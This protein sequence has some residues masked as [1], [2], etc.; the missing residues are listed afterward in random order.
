ME[1]ISII[2]GTT[3]IPWKSI[4]LVLSVMAAFFLS[5][6]LYTA[7]KG[8]RIGMWLWAPP[9]VFLSLFFCRALYWYCNR[10]QYNDFSAAIRDYTPDGFAMLGIVPA[11]VLA[12]VFIRLI[13]LAKSLP[14]MLDAIAPGIS[15]GMGLS[16]LMCLF[17]IRCRGKVVVS[18]PV[19][20]HLPFSAPMTMPQGGVEYRFATFFIGFLV[21]LGIMK[22]CMEFYAA[23]SEEKGCTAALFL[24]L[25]SA[26]GFILDSTRYDAGYFPFNGFVSV[27][28][29]FAGLS[30][31]GLAIG[32]CVRLLKRRG[33]VWYVIPWWVAMLLSM[34]ATGYLEYLVQRYGDRYLLLYSL[35]ALSCL[36]MVLLVYV[37]YALGRKKAETV[38]ETEEQPQEPEPEKTAAAEENT[39]AVTA[40]ENDAEEEEENPAVVPAGLA[41]V[42][43]VLAA[44]GFS[45]LL[46]SKKKKE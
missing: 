24:L 23:R 27:L 29:I 38:E 26:S 21:M 32:F 25:Y 28:Q 10:E 11:V 17:D 8:G 15:L 20:C 18:T 2:V 44:L 39:V 37:I 30:I 16:Y 36:A 33:F 4:L 46:F 41:A 34:G 35:M 12:A 45:A 13:R 3:E 22:L 19:F 31:L 7:H 1:P 14:A 40:A 42:S 5:Y 43:A 6:S 9:A